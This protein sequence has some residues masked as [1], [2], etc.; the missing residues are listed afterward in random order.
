MTSANKRVHLRPGLE[1]KEKMQ[2]LSIAGYPTSAT[3]SVGFGRLLIELAVRAH[4][5]FCAAQK[6][7]MWLSNYVEGRA[8]TSGKFRRTQLDLQILARNIQ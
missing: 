2:A 7:A 6:R 3:Q 5:E 4:S 1:R 8:E